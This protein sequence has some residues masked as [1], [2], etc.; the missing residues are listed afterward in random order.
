MIRFQHH[1]KRFNP[2]QS[3]IFVL[4]LFIVGFCRYRPRNGHKA[5]RFQTRFQL[6]DLEILHVV[7]VCSGHLV[8]ENHSIFGH[9]IERLSYSF[10]LLIVFFQ[11]L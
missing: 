1:S 9:N 11:I 6:S 5:S 7:Q 3:H 4:V 8:F 10:G 2:Y